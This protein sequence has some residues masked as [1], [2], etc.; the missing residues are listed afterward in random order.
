MK[1]YKCCQNQTDASIQ[2]TA[3]LLRIIAEPNRLKIL[4]VLKEGKQ[5]VCNIQKNIRLPQN[6][7]SHH[8]KVL[9]NAGLVKS[10]K[11]GLKIIYSLNK[12]AIKK[13]NSLIANFLQIYEK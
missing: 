1:K 6:L 9:K 7:T 10:Q 13:F 12:T 5:C 2:R 3:E 11:Q 4:C 8:L